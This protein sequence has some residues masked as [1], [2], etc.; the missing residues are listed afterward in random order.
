V[1][2]HG[3]Q[4][5]PDP[6]LGLKEMRRVLRSGYYAAATTRRS[7]SSVRR[8]ERLKQLPLGASFS[9]IAVE[10]QQHQDT[11]ESFAAYWRTVEN[12]VGTLP[13]ANRALPPANQREVR[14]EVH[15]RLAKYVSDGQLELSLET[16]IGAGRA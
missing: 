9:D 5:L 10:R 13:Q 1:C 11:L 2:Q 4:F 12:G 7:A 6:A 14:N 16:L 3:L 15:A 8:T